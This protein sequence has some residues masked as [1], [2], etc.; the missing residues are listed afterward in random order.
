[1][2]TDKHRTELNGVTE[3]IIGCAYTVLNTLGCGF[4]EKV[5]EN[6]LV[7]EMRR[8]GLNVRQQVPFDV[9]Y[10]GELVGQ[11]VADLL[12]EDSVLVELK[13]VK[14]AGRC[15]S[16]PMPQ[17]PESVRAQ[18]VSAAELRQAQTGHQ[19]YSQLNP[20]LSV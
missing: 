7:L 10:R 20:C 17:L 4:L 15:P 5:Y 16:G 8:A 12:V 11:Y 9:R 3:T 2:N 1:M 18:A 14:G 13:A 19:A 6:A